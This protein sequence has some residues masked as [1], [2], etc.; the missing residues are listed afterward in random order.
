MRFALLLLVLT[1]CGG[2][3]ESRLHLDV[4]T[5]FE[6]GTEFDGVLVVLGDREEALS[7]TRS[8]DFTLGVRVP[9]IP[10]SP[11]SHRVRVSLL[12]AG[13]VFAERVLAFESS[14]SFSATS[15]I[16]VPTARPA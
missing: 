14:S 10:L 15:S 8:D 6:P 5:D 16:A 2:D 7:A 12:R 9:S 4:R 13:E 11:G 3:D 1:A